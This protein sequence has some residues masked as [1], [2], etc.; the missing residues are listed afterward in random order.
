[1]IVAQARPGRRLSAGAAGRRAGAHRRRRQRLRLSRRPAAR[2]RA[3][4]SDRLGRP[5]C[6]SSAWPASRRTARDLHRHDEPR[7]A[8]RA[9]FCGCPTC[10]CRSPSSLGARDLCRRRA[11]RAV[12]VA[13]MVLIS[14][15]LVRQFILLDENRAPA[16]HRRRHG[17]ARPVH[18]TR[19]PGAVQRPAGPRDAAA[20]AHGRTGRAC[21]SPT[22]TTSSSSTTASDTP[23]ATSC[24]AAW[25]T[26]IQ[27]ACAPG[28]PSPGSAATSSP[29][30]VEDAP[31]IADAARRPRG[32][33]PS[34]NPS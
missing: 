32:P 34:T 23:S 2:S 11:A 19:Q 4:S 15:A 14:A 24:C 26:G 20:G 29:I 8:A 6:A 3:P 28:T 13:G 10:R 27:P 30:L 16:R 17:A 1:M 21:W 33:R 7:D 25:A 9:V 18:R 5:A 12:L 22:S 31:A